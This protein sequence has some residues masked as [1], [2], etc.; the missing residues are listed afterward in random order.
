MFYHSNLTSICRDC[1]VVRCVECGE[2]TGEKAAEP[3]T[4]V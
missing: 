3:L 2:V 1:Y 4:T